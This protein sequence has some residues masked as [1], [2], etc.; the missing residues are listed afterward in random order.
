MHKTIIDMTIDLLSNISLR[1]SILVNRNTFQENNL[2]IQHHRKNIGIIDINI[3]PHIHHYQKTSIWNL[4][5]RNISMRNTITLLN[6]HMPLMDKV[7]L[8]EASI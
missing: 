7:D 3:I 6:P 5:S 8:T 1:T 4:L 2:T